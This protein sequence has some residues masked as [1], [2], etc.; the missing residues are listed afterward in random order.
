LEAEPG[1]KDKSKMEKF[2]KKVNQL[3]R[4]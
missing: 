2:F 1:K 4:Q 3:R